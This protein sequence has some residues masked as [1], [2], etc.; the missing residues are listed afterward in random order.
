MHQ[1]KRGWFPTI[2]V[3]T[4]IVSTNVSYLFYFLIKL[5]FDLFIVLKAF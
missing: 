3:E 5:N 1:L 2:N 4:I